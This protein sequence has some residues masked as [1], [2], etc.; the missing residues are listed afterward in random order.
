MIVYRQGT[1]AINAEE[2][3]PSVSNIALHYCS[4]L[5]TE[6]TQFKRRNKVVGGG[7]GKK[8]RHFVNTSPTRTNHP[9]FT[10]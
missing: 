10:L 5:A 1:G 8:K 3:R 9:A 2:R 7:H 6:K 4:A